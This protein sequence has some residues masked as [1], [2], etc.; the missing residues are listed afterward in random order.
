[1]LGPLSNTIHGVISFT[2]PMVLISVIILVSFRIAY[3]FKNH[4]KLVLY[5]D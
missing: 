2:W 4:E 5:K 1:M 3:L